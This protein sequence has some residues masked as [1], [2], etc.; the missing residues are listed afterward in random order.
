MPSQST[1]TE[2]GREI[3][4]GYPNF[5]FDPN[6]QLLVEPYLHRGVRL[7]ELEDEVDRREE[8]ASAGCSAGAG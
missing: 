4:G 7:K 5:P 8:D 6:R 1:P 2:W 3:G